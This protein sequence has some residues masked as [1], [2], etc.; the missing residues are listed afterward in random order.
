MSEHDSATQNRVQDLCNE[1]NNPQTI[2]FTPSMKQSYILEDPEFQA[3]GLALYTDTHSCL[4]GI[5]GANNL[6]IDHNLHVRSYKYLNLPE[7]KPKP[8]GG[9]PLPSAQPTDDTMEKIHISHIKEIND[10]NMTMHIAFF[11]AM[12]IFGHPDIQNAAPLKLL[13]SD[14]QLVTLR[15]YH[16]NSR[17]TSQMEKW[18]MLF[19]NI[20]EYLPPS[21]LGL[22]LELIKFILEGKDNFPS[23]FDENIIKLILASH[24]IFLELNEMTGT[25]YLDAYGK[26][27][28]L[29]MKELLL[30]LQ[31]DPLKPLHQFSNDLNEDVVFTI[32]CI[33]ILEK[34]G[35]ITVHRPGIISAEDLDLYDLSY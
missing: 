11:D 12:F 5:T 26:D 4:Q 15:Y 17:Y 16:S 10:L 2:I 13:R 1:C 30:L 32:Y 25:E 14:S 3:R 35:S 9:I 31:E 8:K 19:I 18:L 22:V 21:R 20:F 33:L 24:E 6:F 28:A 23:E 27:E 34:H 7:Y 29:T